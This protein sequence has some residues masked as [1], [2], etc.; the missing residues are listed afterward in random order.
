MLH[1][2]RKFYTGTNEHEYELQERLFRF[3]LTLSV[4]ITVVGNLETAIITGQIR[5]VAFVF[6]GMFVLA[7]LL[8]ALLKKGKVD[9]AILAVGLLIALLVIPVCFFFNG[10]I[11]AGAPVWFTIPFI[12]GF[13]LFSG[14]RLWIF[15]GI[16]F[17]DD[18]LVV[19]LAYIHPEYIIPMDNSVLAYIDTLFSIVIVGI[20]MGGIIRFQ[21]QLYEAE[22]A[23]ALQ[24]KEKIEKLSNSREQFFASMSHELRSPI[25]SIVGLNELIMRES[26]DLKVQEYSRNIFQTSRMLLNLINDILDFSQI[27]ISKMNIVKLPYDTKN[28]FQEVLDM[29]TVRMQEKELEFRVQIDE[30]LPRKLV[31]DKKRIQQI[32]LNLLTNAV[33]YTKEGSVTLLVYGEKLSEQQVQISIT[34]EDTGIGIKKENLEFLYDAFRRINEE[35]TVKIEGSGLGLAITKQLVGL[36]GG[37]IKV[38]SIYTKGSK[39]TVIV[40]QEIEDPTPMNNANFTSHP[41]R[42]L[43]QY[44]PTFYAPEARILIVDDSV[45]NLEVTK[46]LLEQTKLQIDIASSGEECLQK[47]REK[48][49]HVILLDNRMSGMN[50][51]QTCREIRRQENG[52]CRGSEIILRTA[53]AEDVAQKIVEENQF[54][55]YLEK[56][57][58]G[59]RLE[60][61]V[62]E[63]LPC[64]FVEQCERERTYEKNEVTFFQRKKKKICI[65]TDCICDLSEEML[66]RYQIPVMDLYIKTEQGR[67][68]DRKEIDIDSVKYR[69]EEE[70]SGIVTDSATVKEFEQFFAE[71]L[72]EAEEVIHISMA[73]HM[74]N[75][76][77]RAAAAAKSFDHVQVVDAGHLSCGQGLL[78]LKAAKKLEAGATREQLLDYIE[79][80]KSQIEMVVLMPN[81]K[82]FYQNGY[83]SGLVMN[84]CE[85]FQQR[86]VYS[87]R[88]SRLKCISMRHGKLDRAWKGFVHSQLRNKRNIDREILIIS[89]AGCSAS[90]LEFLRQEIE[91]ELPFT[92]IIMMKTS[93][94]TACSAGLYVVGMAFSKK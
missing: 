75:T 56:P 89:H 25:N 32:L 51:S 93:V 94:S 18:V 2:I 85:F 42:Q 40:D 58:D 77:D 14:R 39:F 24:Q 47:T 80:Q 71:A 84:V 27:E 22:Y 30:T 33:K 26:S 52:L 92:K 36:M 79:E 54:S 13:L 10:G 8:P 12:Y 72:T 28:M 91:K 23:L 48:F 73:R 11:H 45:V 87:M 81:T 17:C 34:V 78:V 7:L 64:D 69:L 41:I 50:G 55:G 70:Q 86:P 37:Q 31:G 82:F 15:L 63:H 83:T 66:E 9:I 67:F 46:K 6:I 20:G 19:V 49:Y 16:V 53:E 90:Q 3:L 88:Q 74:G 43:Q 62:L 60:R 59:M 35:N 68:A 44:V 61:M 4:G 76:Y 1:R 21:I 29:I 57:A 5:F 65:T 38:D